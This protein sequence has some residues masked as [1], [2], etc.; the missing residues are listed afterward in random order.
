MKKSLLLTALAAATALLMTACSGTAGYNYDLTEYIT[1]GTYKGVEVSQATLDEELQTEIDTLIDDNT[2]TNEITDRAAENGD[3]VNIDYAG[4]LNGEV[5]T[6]TAGTQA[7]DSNI[8]ITLGAG[9]MIDGFEEAIVGHS[10][11]DVINVDLTFPE[12]YEASEELRGV[13]LSF[14]ITVNKISETIVPEYNDAFVAEK[15]DFATVDEYEADTLATKREDLVWNTIL[16]NSTVIKYPEKNV[17]NY[18]DNMVDTYKAYA[19]SYGYSFDNFIT[20]YMG[21]DTETFLK[22]LITSAKSTVKNELVI[23]TIS[24][25]EGIEVTNEE[26]NAR[27][28]KYVEQYSVD[29]TKALEDK[30]GKDAITLTILYDMVLEY[31]VANSVTVD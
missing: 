21:Q 8:D 25:A 24:R 31:V 1:V 12:D 18:Y 20:S 19:S 2:T 14:E 26:Y 16:E 28:G 23:Y 4:Y 30:Y 13:T 11:G 17:K 7:A 29:D 6:D 5:F 27:V 10:T 22:S 9:V 15:T 3:K